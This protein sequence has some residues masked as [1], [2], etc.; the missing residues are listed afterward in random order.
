MS[1]R[2]DLETVPPL[3]R[4]LAERINRLGNRIETYGAT[5]LAADKA[6]LLDAF[7]DL[8]AESERLGD[9]LLTAVIDKWSTYYDGRCIDN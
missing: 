5:L 8:R 3:R 4:G 9:A 1:L 7:A 2:V 6:E